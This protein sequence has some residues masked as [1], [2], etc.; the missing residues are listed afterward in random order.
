MDN[1]GE[2]IACLSNSYQMQSVFA[3]R[4]FGTIPDRAEEEGV[5]VALLFVSTA[6]A[7]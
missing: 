3:E 1:G 6:L 5:C 7:S 4:G 2:G